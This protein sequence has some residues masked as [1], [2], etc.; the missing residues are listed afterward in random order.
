MPQTP[1]YPAWKFYPSHMAPPSWVPQFVGTV[2]TA[3]PLIDTAHVAGLTSSMP[4]TR[5]DVSSCRSRAFCSSA[6]DVLRVMLHTRWSG[7]GVVS[8][9]G[10][11]QE[12]ARVEESDSAR[13]VVQLT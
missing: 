5:A 13:G 1:P 12:G 7:G 3:R 2:A 6:T 11:I 10:R 4:S 8:G 9:Q